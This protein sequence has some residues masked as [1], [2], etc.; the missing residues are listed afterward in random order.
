[1]VLNFFSLELILFRPSNLTDLILGKR[2][3]PLTQVR[4]NC[5]KKITKKYLH[6]FL[7]VHPSKFLEKQAKEKINRKKFIHFHNCKNCR[8]TRFED[9]IFF[10]VVNN[11]RLL[12]SN[13]THAEMLFKELS[14]CR[15]LK[16]F[17]SLQ[18][19][20]VNFWYFKLR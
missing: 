7:V 14:L 18:P 8:K 19:G 13:K 11:T 9:F 15:K 6:I 16:F 4:K 17:K 12:N 1:M 3:L 2:N 10:Q 5:F 20:G